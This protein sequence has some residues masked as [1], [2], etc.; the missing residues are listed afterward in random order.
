[1]IIAIAFIEHIIFVL[2]YVFKYL[3]FIYIRGNVIT[4]RAIK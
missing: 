2:G 1:M 4:R 3:I